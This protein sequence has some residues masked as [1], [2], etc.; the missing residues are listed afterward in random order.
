MASV[1]FSKSS[2]PA[3]CTYTS[4][5]YK[6]PF[7]NRICEAQN[8][9]P[10]DICLDYFFSCII[11]EGEKCQRV[12]VLGCVWVSGWMHVLFIPPIV[13]CPA[14]TTQVQLCHCPALWCSS[15]TLCPIW[16]CFFLELLC[17]LVSGISKLF[18]DLEI[19][20]TTNQSPP[21]RWI[22]KKPRLRRR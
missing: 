14:G 4:L 9:F 10:W 13:W 16:L 22:R 6:S 17:S 18:A 21:P 1:L 11:S 5:V 7:C 12:C 3:A 19:W 2:V 8:N 15:K 20:K